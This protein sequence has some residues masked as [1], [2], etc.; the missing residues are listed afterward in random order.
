MNGYFELQLV[1]GIF[2]IDKKPETFDKNI[3]ANVVTYCLDMEK[4]LRP[5]EDISI[6]EVK[7]PTVKGLGRDPDL[8]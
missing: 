5:S 7:V 4:N 3:L 1:L 6:E 2:F 8:H